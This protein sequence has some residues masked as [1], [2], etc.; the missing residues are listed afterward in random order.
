MFSLLNSLQKYKCIILRLT[1][2]ED[3]DGEKWV[4]MD[5]PDIDSEAIGRLSD[6]YFGE[7]QV[8][9][10]A[11]EKIE[12]ST[13][14]KVE[15]SEDYFGILLSFQENILLPSYNL[16]IIE[17]VTNQITEFVKTIYE[18]TKFSY[19]FCDHEAEFQYSTTDFKPEKY[20]ISYLP[21]DGTL[22]VI[23]SNWHINGLTER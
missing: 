10:N 14:I 3:I 7:I 17:A 5:N 1:Y 23:K 4:E 6:Y 19:A 12:L 15:K 20:S 21:E 8:K 13:S 22:R 2:S 16:E 11:F 18:D 9:I